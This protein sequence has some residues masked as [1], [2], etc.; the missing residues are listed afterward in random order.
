MLWCYNCCKLVPND[1]SYKCPECGLGY[2][3]EELSSVGVNQD[4]DPDTPN[5]TIPIQISP[6]TV[7]QG[8]LTRVAIS[9]AISVANLSQA[10][11][12]SFIQAILN[13]NS[14]G[15]TDIT[16]SFGDYFNGDDESLRE[17]AEHLFRIDRQ[18]LGSPP[19]DKKYVSDLESVPF[20]PSKSADDVCLICLEQ[21]EEKEKVIILECGH[22][23]HPKCLAPWLQMHSECPSCRHKLPAD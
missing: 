3:E 14:Q 4:A 11:L 8:D 23:F 21:L 18:S 10:H 6:V 1:E 16:A 9:M 5:R 17:L 12:F 2:L 15:N 13:Q 19:A 20:D 22:P 7:V